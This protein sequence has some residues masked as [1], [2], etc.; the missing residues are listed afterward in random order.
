MCK[1]VMVSG[2]VFC[3]SPDERSVCFQGRGGG[4]RAISPGDYKRM[5]IREQGLVSRAVER[6]APLTVKGSA[7]TRNYKAA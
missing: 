1:Q 3:L 6:L 5:S 7:L 2:Y 4:V